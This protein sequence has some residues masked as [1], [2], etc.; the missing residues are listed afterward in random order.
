[1]LSAGALQ[2]A[3]GSNGVT[4][5]AAQAQAESGIHLA[6]YYLTHPDTA[7]LSAGSW[8]PTAVSFVSTQP[9][10]TMSGSVTVTVATVAG[11]TN[12]Y[13]VTA[14]GSVPTSTD[15]QQI[16]RTITAELEVMPSYQITGAGAFNSSAIKITSGVT[17][18]GAISTTGTINIQGTG[19]VN[20]DVSASGFLGGA[21]NGHEN[22]APSSPPAPA[23]GT[24]TD[25]S[26]PYY[27]QGTLYYPGTVSGTGG[28]YGPQPSNP[29][30]IY[31][32][33][34]SLTVTGPLIVTGTLYIKNGTLGDKSTIT[35]NPVALSQMTYSLPALVVDQAIQM[36]A[37]TTLT[38]SGV[39]CTNTGITNTLANSS[40]QVNITGALLI[41]NTTGLITNGSA[42]VN[43][44][45]NSSYT[46]VLN[47]VANE[48]P[49]IK[50]ISWS[51]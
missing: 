25:Y 36:R 47:L 48:P 35:I 32:N 2:A 17:I 19:T 41:T 23:V 8:G 50:V 11:S 20:G 45:Y 42:K 1:M 28:T 51:E 29:L 16:T 13:D 6:A 22:P 7:P 40:T 39:V 10:T 12:C 31:Y 26:Q 33:S 24:V 34:G 21:P 38:V 18:N 49:A 44:T 37:N 43:I 30:G 15:G 4:A 14:V 46:N 3:A 5:A 27:Y 9:P